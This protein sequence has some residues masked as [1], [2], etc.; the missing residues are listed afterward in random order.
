MRTH[1]LLLLVHSYRCRF[2][3]PEAREDCVPRDHGSLGVKE[4]DPYTYLHH[5]VNI[6]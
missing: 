6:C 3:S 5:K 2:G 4:V 1:N